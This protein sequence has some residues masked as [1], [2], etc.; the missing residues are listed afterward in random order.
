V[1]YEE[2]SPAVHL[3]KLEVETMVADMVPGDSYK[4]NPM[5]QTLKPEPFAL[6]PKVDLQKAQ[7]TILVLTA[8]GSVCMSVVTGYD[9]EMHHFHIYSAP[10]T[11]A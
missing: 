9:A 8:G 2:H 4:V 10:T 11:T 1:H 6:K 7:R 3:H 5:L